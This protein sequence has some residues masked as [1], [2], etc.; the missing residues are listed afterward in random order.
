[1]S[2]PSWD[3][4]FM[5]Q[6]RNI[7]ERSTCTRLSVGAVLVKDNKPLMQGYNGSL[8]GHDHCTDVGCLMYEGS[9]KRTIHAERNVIDSCAS[10]GIPMKGATLY[11]THYP[12]PDCMRSIANVGVTR[13]VYGEMYAHKYT[14]NF[15]E[16]ILIEAYKESDN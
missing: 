1:M 6:A 12:C 10:F 3:T 13:I 2:R 15:H 11:V 16:G 8:P 14:N 7:A 4:I 9:C 5:T